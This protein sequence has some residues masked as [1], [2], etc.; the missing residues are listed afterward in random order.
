VSPLLEIGRVVRPHGLRG[1]VVVELWTNRGERLAEGSRLLG[2]AGEL[3]V[4]RTSPSA[5]SG[6]HHRCIVA[7]EQIG[8]REAAEALRGAVLRA[9][10][11]RDDDA[12]WVHDLVGSQVYTAGGEMIGRVEYVEANPASDLLVL[13]DGRL[14]PLTFVTGTAEGRVTVDPPAGLLQL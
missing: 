7:F 1:Q 4:V 8:T 5:P 11:I 12:L 2:P 14:I 6:G 10:A 3:A 9:E 13:E